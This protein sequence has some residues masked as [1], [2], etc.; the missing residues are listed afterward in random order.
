MKKADRILTEAKQERALILHAYSIADELKI[1]KI[2]IQ[3]CGRHHVDFLREYEVNCRHIW[4]TRNPKSLPIKQ[5]KFHVIIKVPEIATG[6]NFLTLGHFLALLTGVV[7]INEPVI[8][9]TAGRSGMLNGISIT[10]TA[11]QLEWLTDDYLE[12]FV[13]IENPQTLVMLINIAMRFAREGREGR[14]IGTCF[15]LKNQDDVSRYSWQLILNPCEGYPNNIRNIFREDFFETLRELSALDGAFLVEPS[16]EVRAAAVYM[17]TPEHPSQMSPGLGA[18][19]NSAAA[20]T[21][22]TD[23]LAVVLS[24]SSG[25]II[26]YGRGKI[27]L[28][29]S[30]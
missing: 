3:A 17:A 16:G 23:A 2:I 19:H 4:L 9:I 30:R 28:K 22:H 11:R 6:E 20:L 26:V 1:S 18:R 10:S 21:A 25:T 12:D 8:C 14:P 24:E 13:Q 7:L 29:F 5:G 15:I 27:I